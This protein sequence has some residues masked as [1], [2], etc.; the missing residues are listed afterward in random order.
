MDKIIE[1]LKNSLSEV[2]CERPKGMP[3]NIHDER[4]ERSILKCKESIFSI[5]ANSKKLGGEL[6]ELINDLDED[7]GGALFAI[8]NDEINFQFVKGA[9]GSKYQTRFFLIPCLAESDTPVANNAERVSHIL[10]NIDDYHLM[11]GWKTKFVSVTKHMIDA[12]LVLRSI[13]ESLVLS[14]NFAQNTVNAMLNFKNENI[15]CRACGVEL[16]DA[17]KNPIGDGEI[18]FLAG[19]VV[20]EGDLGDNTVDPIIAQDCR[21]RLES[22]IAKAFGIDNDTFCIT[23]PATLKEA[24]KDGGI[25]MVLNL[26]RETAKEFMNGADEIEAVISFDIPGKETT[27]KLFEDNEEFKEYLI[28]TPWVNEENIQSTIKAIMD[29]MVSAG[30]SNV[31]VE[32]I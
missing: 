6:E 4:V 3:V 2:V 28:P 26:F 31:M 14:L 19:C 17:E 30:G 9:D 7:R 29:T 13:N 20:F 27:L 32:I 8:I 23:P 5:L 11:A 12:E 1:I 24:L 15:N 16:G 10:K 21:A 22:E 25:L 18:K